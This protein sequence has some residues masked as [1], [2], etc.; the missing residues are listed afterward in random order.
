VRGYVHVVKEDSV[1]PSLLFVGTELGLWISVD[2]G[3]D[4]AEFKGGDFPNVAV[5]DLAVQA[6]D[7]DLVIGTHGR[8]IWI[9]DDLSPL[10]ALT[11]DVL[12]RDAAFL[13]GRPVEQ[14]MQ[15]QGGWVQGDAAF[16]GDNPAGG[17][18]ITFYQRTRHLV[19]PLKIEILDA[20]GAVV[21][22]LSPP[23]RRGINRVTWSMQVK[24]PRVPR[25]A[26]L[27]GGATQGPRVLPGTYTVR[28]T[29]GKEV[30]ETK[31]VIG[32]DRRAPFT[33]ADRKE[34]FDAAM[35]V[36]ALFG[37]MSDLVSRI[38]GL[39]VSVEK[40][41]R[42][43][44]EKDALRS[45]LKE[46]AIRLDEAKKKIVATKEGGAVTGEERIR[47]HADILYGAL[48]RWEGRP[49]RYQVERIDT[50]RK[51]LEDVAGEVSKLTTDDL[52]PPTRSSNPAG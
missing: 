39:R 33:L 46:L 5:R 23:K 52:I 26:T 19:G 44:P 35:K 24:P 12:A 36:H 20:S 37:D 47:E 28:M 15:A 3:N 49:A 43:L 13:P 4:W 38:E 27:A 9:I 30:L 50:L 2:G 16:V 10:R 18:T 25:A 21:D 11:P 32:L 6:R 29:K 40:R 8:G 45:D 34:Q 31:L 7:G 51:E 48:L 41:A 42:S 14:R 17:A 22:T 1:D